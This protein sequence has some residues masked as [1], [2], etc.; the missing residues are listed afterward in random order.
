MSPFRSIIKWITPPET[1]PI[2]EELFVQAQRV[3]EIARQVKS[4]GHELDGTWT[5]GARNIFFS[6]YD[7]LPGDLD[8][9]ANSL[10]SKARSIAAITV[11]IEVKEWFEDI[12][13]R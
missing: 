11:W 13:Q 1:R 5:G 7:P 2:V 3:R 4:V 9:F 10:E 6:H 8:R 12:T